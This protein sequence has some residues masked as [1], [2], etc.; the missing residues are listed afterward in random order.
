[1]PILA[2]VASRSADAVWPNREPAPAEECLFETIF[3]LQRD[4]EAFK[5]TE[6]TLKERLA[7]ELAANADTVYDAYRKARPD[8]SP[9]ELYVAI[10]TANMIGIGAVTI[11][12]RKVAHHMSEMWSTFARNGRPAATGQPAW[13]AYDTKSRATMEIK[14]ECRVVNDP[15]GAERAMWEKL[16]V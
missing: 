1:M 2:A 13:P 6:G 15:Y 9:S 16:D 12:E 14:A 10:T 8:A 5:L 4:A 11:A 3:F 7:K